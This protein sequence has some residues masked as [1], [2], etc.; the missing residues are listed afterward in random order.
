[1]VPMAIAK[2]IYEMVVQRA[3]FDQLFTII[4]FSL[5]CGFSNLFGQF[6]VVY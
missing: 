3:Y 4:S 1:M 5:A 2:D 6:V